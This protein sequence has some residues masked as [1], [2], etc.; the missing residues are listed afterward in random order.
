MILDTAQLRYEM[1][2]RGL[3]GQTLARA[4]GVSKNTVTR[5]RHGQPINPE[6]LRRIAAALL[7][8]PP[9]RMAQGLVARPEGQRPLEPHRDRPRPSAGSP[10]SGSASGQRERPGR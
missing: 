8:F 3:D 5:A 10:P 4:A 2:I 6:T 1:A 7:T 9:L